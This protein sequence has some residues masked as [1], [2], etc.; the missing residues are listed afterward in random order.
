MAFGHPVDVREWEYALDRGEA[1]L[2]TYL[3]PLD[4][5]GR[6]LASLSIADEIVVVA[7]VRGQSLELAHSEVVWQRGDSAAV[8]SR[9]RRDEA[10]AMLDDAAV[11]RVKERS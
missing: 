6:S 5:A 7:R 9:V 11:A 2:M 8:L 3:V 1:H 4:W 10:E